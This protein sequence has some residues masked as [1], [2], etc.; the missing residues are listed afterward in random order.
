M[1]R[2]VGRSPADDGDAR[3]PSPPAGHDAAH[4]WAD[5]HE[6]DPTHH[7]GEARDGRSE[8]RRGVAHED[9]RAASGRGPRGRSSRHRD[10]DHGTIRTAIGTR[11]TTDDRESAP[12]RDDAPTGTIRTAVGPRTTRTIGTRARGAAVVLARPCGTTFVAA[13]WAP[14]PIGARRGRRLTGATGGTRAVVAGATA[15][16]L[17]GSRTDAPS[18]EP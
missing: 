4:Q 7:Q 2:D 15:S 16:T 12:I 11:T 6:D 10:E 5:H 18:R 3:H 9:D 8:R 14:R 17:A 1:L 13:V